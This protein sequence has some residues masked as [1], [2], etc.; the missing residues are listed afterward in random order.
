MKG[1]RIFLGIVVILIGVLWLLSNFNLITVFTLTRLW[2]YW[3]LFLILWGLLLLLDKNS[4]HRTGWLEL[5]FLLGAIILVIIVG[6]VVIFSPWFSYFSHEE[7]HALTFNNTIDNIYRRTDTLV[8]N[9][10]GDFRLR[11]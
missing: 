10:S 8:L 6:I 2:R 7:R 9:H 3:P 1:T 11:P 5:F 4:S